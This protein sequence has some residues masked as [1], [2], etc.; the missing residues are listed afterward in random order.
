[1]TSHRVF[2]LLSDPKNLLHANTPTCTLEIITCRKCQS[3]FGAGAAVFALTSAARWWYSAA[4]RYYNA[5]CYNYLHEPYAHL[6][7]KPT[8][9]MSVIHT[10][11]S[12]YN[13]NDATTPTIAT[14]Q[15]RRRQQ[16]HTAPIMS[17]MLSWTGRDDGPNR[18][19]NFRLHAMRLQYMTAPTPPNNINIIHVYSHPVFCAR[20]AR[21]QKMGTRTISHTT[22]HMHT[23]KNP[24]TVFVVWFVHSTLHNAGQRSQ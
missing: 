20:R 19:H 10:T 6:S 9:T 24:Y 3:C 7:S 21:G 1:M 15:R 22:I 14:T 4:F 16:R 5:Q 23:H 18:T 8:K 13:F 2:T 11:W 12:D 17:Q